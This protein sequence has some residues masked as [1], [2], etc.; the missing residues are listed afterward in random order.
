[1]N[2]LGPKIV[3]LRHKVS[4]SFWFTPSVILLA[5]IALSALTL[6]VDRGPTGAWIQQAPWIYRIG[7]EGARLMLSTVA[8]SMITVTS[9]VFSLTLVALTLAS[10]QLGPRVIALFM[11]NRVNQLVLGIFLAT[12]VYAL[13]I[14]RTINDES[15]IIFVPHVSLIVALLLAIACF[16]LLIFFIHHAALLIQADT[17]LAVIAGAAGEAIEANFPDRGSKGG[18]AARRNDDP[19][20][21]FTTDGK[22]VE[23]TKS[24]Y[25]QVVSRDALLETAE[26]DGVTIKMECRA[27]HFVFASLPIAWAMPAERVDE[28]VIDGIRAAIVLGPR[29]TPAQ[30]VEFTLRAIVD[31]VVRA[32]SPSLNDFHT[33]MAGIDRL[34]AALS[35]ILQRD[36]PDPICRSADDGRE[37]V[38]LYPETL[39]RM[40]HAAFQQIIESSRGNTTIG[41]HLIVTFTALALVAQTSEQR[42][43][44]RNRADA[45]ARALSA[46]AADPHDKERVARRLDALAA[47]LGEDGLRGDS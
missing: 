10:Q 4:S 8:G 39:E 32:L 35:E 20:D 21:N 23:A 38:Y 37:A 7:A 16:G 14:L 2:G 47:A 1:M 24:G 9:L 42:E 18:E 36:M 34:G 22:A 30:D 41:I 31:I 43:I 5:S 11:E 44:I 19:P 46:D 29:R 25:V 17:M 13:L 45:V 15:G 12:F 40:F 26:R 27:G 28:R 3:Y 33:A 6:A